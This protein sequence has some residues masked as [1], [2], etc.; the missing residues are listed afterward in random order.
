MNETNFKGPFQEMDEKAWEELT[1]KEKALC[2]SYKKL[3]ERDK[4][5]HQLM[6]NH[7]NGIH[8]R[9]PEFH[10]GCVPKEVGNGRI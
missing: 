3:L 10:M 5:I 1:P 2:V 8:L 4:K 9:H 6:M 7:I